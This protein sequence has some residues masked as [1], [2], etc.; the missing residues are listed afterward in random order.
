[1]A[2][3]TPKARAADQRVGVMVME[4]QLQQAENQPVGIDK[5][6]MA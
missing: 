2:P 1:M 4:P 6:F 5:Y 3:V